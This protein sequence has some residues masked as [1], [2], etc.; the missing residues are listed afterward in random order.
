MA[1]YFIQESET[2]NIKI[3]K[4]PGRHRM[5]VMQTGNSSKLKLLREI[6]GEYDVETILHKLFARDRISTRREWFRPSTSLIKFLQLDNKKLYTTVNNV[7][8]LLKRNK[9]GIIN[10][11]FG[12]ETDDDVIERIVKEYGS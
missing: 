12:G 1:V 4:G 3:G 7:W 5:Q 11:K 10:L 9:G 8:A 2:G 6:P